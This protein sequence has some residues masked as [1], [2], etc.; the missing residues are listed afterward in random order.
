MSS[1]NPEASVHRQQIPHTCGKCHV[2]V[3]ETYQRSIHG[4]R[5]SEDDPNAPVCIDC[6]T[7]HSITHAGTS[8]F[9][10]DV[11]SECGACHDR[12]SMR[13]DRSFYETYR[14]SYHGQVTA[15]GSMRAARCSDC[16]GSSHNALLRKKCPGSLYAPFELTNYALCFECHDPQS[17]LVEKTDVATDFRNGE[18]NLHFVHVNRKKKGR[19]CKTCHELHGAQQPKQI[20]TNVEFTRQWVMPLGFSKTEDGGSCAP[21]CHEAVSYT[22]GKPAVKTDV[23]DGDG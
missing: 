7:T 20:A 5:L 2:G 13:T 15:L 10:M 1:D 12:P 23:G 19:T 3:V 9:T 6:H 21:Q 22:R 8:Q 16:H 11:I 4:Q 18:V 14:K 17:V